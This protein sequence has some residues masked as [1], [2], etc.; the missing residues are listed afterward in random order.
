LTL[1]RTRY[2]VICV[3]ERAFLLSHHALF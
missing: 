1:Q 3:R 2:I